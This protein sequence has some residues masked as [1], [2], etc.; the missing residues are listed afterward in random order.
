MRILFVSESW[1]PAMN[2]VATSSA[3]VVEELRGHGHEVR[4]IAPEVTEHTVGLSGLASRDPHGYSLRVGPRPE[5][6]LGLFDHRGAELMRSWRPHLVHVASPLSLGYQALS[7]AQRLGIPSI[8]AYLTDFP[9]FTRQ[10]LGDRP[11]AQ[12]LAGLLGRVQRR[13][14]AMATVNI[15]CSRYALRTLNAWNSPRARAWLRCVDLARFTP[16][17]RATRLAGHRGAAGAPRAVTP[18]RIGYAGRLAPEK[19]L[20]LLAGLDGLPGVELQLIGDGPSRE[21]LAHQ[22]PAAVFTGRLAGAEYPA[23]LS[24]LDLFVHPGRGETLSQVVLE[25]LQSWAEPQTPLPYQ[26]T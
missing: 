5:Y 17:A 15:A 11:G 6:T 7:A 13:A 9:R 8:A 26:P 24:A 16:D 3:R 1:P 12:P 23:A 4:V 25:A 2:G 22:L 20:Q 21:R 18:V 19:E 10:A 14:H